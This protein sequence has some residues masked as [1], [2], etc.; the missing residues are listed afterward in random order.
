MEKR[1][2]IEYGFR[3]YTG[4][5]WTRAHVEAYNQYQKKINQWLDV[6]GYVPEQLLNGSHNLFEAFSS[7]KLDVPPRS[8]EKKMRLIN[9]NISEEEKQAIAHHLGHMNERQMYRTWR[10]GDLVIYDGREYI[11]YDHVAIENVTRA[12]ITNYDVVL[13]VFWDDIQGKS[14]ITLAGERI[15]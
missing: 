9:Y 10:Y 12:I 11:L 7:P 3:S 15:A 5:V 8:M 13:E 1:L 4:V 14:G 2:M 6:A